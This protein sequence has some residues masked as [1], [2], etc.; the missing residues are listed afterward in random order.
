MRN[1]H[2]GLLVCSSNPDC[3]FGDSSDVFPSGWLFVECLYSI[4]Y[5]KEKKLL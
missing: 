1:V 4:Y 3:V 2:F 5:I